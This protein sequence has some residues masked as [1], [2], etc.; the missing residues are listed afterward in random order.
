MDTLAV[1][2]VGVC[3][4]GA[5]VLAWVAFATL[6]LDER[7][8]AAQ[9]ERAAVAEVE[10]QLRVLADR[11]PMEVDTPTWTLYPHDTPTW[12]LYPHGGAREGESMPELPPADRSWL[13]TEVI[14]PR[15]RRC[16]THTITE[17]Q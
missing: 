2:Q 9:E 5:I 12:T 3:L 16:P 13:R 6:R 7:C 14:K 1:V 11:A 8:R 15:I 4:A 17:D 10:A